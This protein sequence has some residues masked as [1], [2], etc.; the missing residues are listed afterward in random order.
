M[1]TALAQQELKSKSSGV[2]NIFPCGAT[3]DVPGGHLVVSY[4]HLLAIKVINLW[5]L[6][7]QQCLGYIYVGYDGTSVGLSWG[8]IPFS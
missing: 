4:P 2:T 5:S 6:K 1:T 3:D 8:Q 7:D